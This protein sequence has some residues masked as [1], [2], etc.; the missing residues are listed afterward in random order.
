[1]TALNLAHELLA[2]PAPVADGPADTEVSA[3]HVD[4]EEFARRIGSIVARL[5]AAMLEQDKLF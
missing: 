1:M 2:R 5:D 3:S 4:G